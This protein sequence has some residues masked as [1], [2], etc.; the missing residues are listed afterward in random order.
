MQVFEDY[1]TSR[2]YFLAL[3]LGGFRII[4]GPQGEHAEFNLIVCMN[5]QTYCIWKRYSQFSTLVRHARRC[6]SRGQLRRTLEAW[7][8]LEQR[9]K[10]WRCLDVRY[11][12]QKYSLLE[13][14]LKELVYEI[15][16]PAL[17][18]KFS[19]GKL[20]ADGEWC[21]LW[22]GGLLGLF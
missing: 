17:L 7:G 2:S 10:W 12:A 9:R 20:D 21:W 15:K 11:L 6:H 3:G 1:S 19:S 16:S 5:S 18:V 13:L 4:Q 22:L 8:N 14:F